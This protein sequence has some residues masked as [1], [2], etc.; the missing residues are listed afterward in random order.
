MQIVLLRLRQK[1]SLGTKG[2]VP[3]V[4]SGGGI[5]F[6]SILNLSK[7]LGRRLTENGTFANIWSNNR[8]DSVA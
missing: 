1:T 7:N 2:N 3:N 6:P 5:W 4:R 8:V